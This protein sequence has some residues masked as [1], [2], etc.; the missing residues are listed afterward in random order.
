MSHAERISAGDLYED[1]SYEP[2]LCLLS[3]YVQ[4]ELIG[5]SLVNGRVG[6]C[7]H[8]HCGVRPLS[9]AEA[10][11][12]WGHGLLLTWS[13]GTGPRAV[14]FAC[15]RARSQ[16]PKWRPAKPDYRRPR[17]QQF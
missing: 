1:G 14:R 13:S 11:A 17:S 4:G 9:L 5:I 2:M 15:H 10:V 3:D 8:E 7:S 12:I 6:S 16:L